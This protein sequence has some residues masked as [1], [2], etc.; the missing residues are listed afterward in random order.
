MPYP[1]FVAADFT[2]STTDGYLNCAPALG[3]TENMQ[4]LPGEATIVAGGGSIPNDNAGITKVT[5]DVGDILHNL[6]A[7]LSEVYNNCLLYTS[8][9]PRD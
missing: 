7:A 8:P 5:Q 1:N 9:S 6:P 3:S 4:C 2:P